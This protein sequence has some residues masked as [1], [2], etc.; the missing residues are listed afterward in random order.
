[1]NLKLED[2]LLIDCARF[3]KDERI[4]DKIE[5]TLQHNLNWS[6]ILEES[7]R[8]GIGCLIYNYLSQF[9][10][11]IPENIRKSFKQIHYKNT[12]RNIKI[13]QEISNIL[14]SFN[15]ENLGVIPLKGIFL[16]EKVYDNISLRTM[17]DVDILIKKK[18]LLTIDK[19]LY[20]LGFR[21]HISNE[22]LF[23]AL[24]KSYLN[25]V[26]YD[27]FK[28]D[29]QFLDSQINTLHV[30]WHI[31]NITLPTYLYTK[32]INMDK[33]WRCAR[34]T[35]IGGIRTF[36]LAPHHLIM[37][38]S[39]HALK[40]S[41]RSLIHFLD[42]NAAIK[43]YKQEINWHELIKDTLEFGME[44]QVYYSLYF[45]NYFLNT[46]VPEHILEKIK[47][48]NIGIFEKIFFNSIWN[49]KRDTKLCYFVYLNIVKGAM[50]KLRFIFRTLFPPPCVLALSF[51]A[52]KITIK[53]YFLFFKKQLFHLKL[54]F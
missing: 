5:L 2:K 53:T 33:F 41:F 20:D 7:I 26:D 9:K 44:R 50:N 40:H 19:I 49:N 30:H 45:T 39:E 10:N 47:P 24:E 6:Y 38:L 13:Y 31:V 25:S 1:M 54:I 32:N 21:R 36:E 4:K 23:V 22:L 29:A 34:P 42:I 35:E 11:N 17:N 14:S 16:A 15:N 12:Y 37:Y 28:T 52:P 51:N 48:K 18:D 3:V 8:Q 43:K 27:Y 46:Q